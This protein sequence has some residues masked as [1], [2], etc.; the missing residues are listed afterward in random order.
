VTGAT[1]ITAS[2]S[3]GPAQAAKSTITDATARGVAMVLLAT[4]GWSLGGLFTRM[5]TIDIG[6]AVVLRSLAGGLL[7]LLYV[8]MRYRQS[9][10][11][12]LVT[13]GK[14]GWV[15]VLLSSI[16]QAATTAGLFLTSVAHVAVI[17]A[18]CPFV[19]AI[20]AWIWLHERISRTTAIAIV[21]SLVGIMLVVAGSSGPSSLLGDAVAFVMTASFAVIIVLSKAHPGLKI[22]E[23]STVGAFLTSLLFL[24]FFS[25]TDLDVRNAVVVSIY[26]FVA[27][28]FAFLM[29]I[30]GARH[31]PAATSGLIITLEIVLSPF[32]VWLF[33]D[34][35]IDRLT[36]IGGAIVAAAVAGHLILMSTRPRPIPR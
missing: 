1:I 18:T 33:F 30:R 2:E 27:I 21:A 20:I 34:E 8:L 23:I 22:V 7:M 15:V 36:F 10:L 4:L 11:R 19:A 6:T 24:P 3:P 13:L 35:R 25:T 12:E 28:V 9:A 29:F 31:L 16:A 17:Y 14:V 32:W 5:L 26:G